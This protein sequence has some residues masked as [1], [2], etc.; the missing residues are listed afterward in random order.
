MSWLVV[1]LATMTESERKVQMS[2]ADLK[3]EYPH[4]IYEQ[5]SDST[6]YEVFV[7]AS[8]NAM[9]AAGYQIAVE[10]ESNERQG[11]ST[12]TI[13][14]KESDR[15]EQ[16]LQGTLFLGLT[17]ATKAVLLNGN[18]YDNLEVEAAGVSD[19]LLHDLVDDEEMFKAFREYYT[20]LRW[21]TD[22][23]KLVRAVFRYSTEYNEKDI[24]DNLNGGFLG[25]L[26]FD[27]G[28]D[29]KIPYEQRKNWYTADPEQI[30]ARH[31]EIDYKRLKDA[32]FAESEEGKRLKAAYARA[33]GQVTGDAY[34]RGERTITGKGEVLPRPQIPLLKVPIVEALM[35]D[36]VSLDRPKAKYNM[37]P[38]D[39]VGLLAYSS[40]E[41]AHTALVKS[42]NTRVPKDARHVFDGPSEFQHKLG[43]IWDIIRAYTEY[44]SYPD[45]RKL[46]AADLTAILDAYSNQGEIAESVRE[47]HFEYV[48]VHGQK[49]FGE[50]VH[51][52]KE[53][54]IDLL[55]VAIASSDSSLTAKAQEVM[56][57]YIGGA[58]GLVV[59]RDPLVLSRG[60]LVLIV[61]DSIKNFDPTGNPTLLKN[62]A[63]E[64]LGGK[65]KSVADLA[66]LHMTAVGLRQKPNVSLA[67]KEMRRHS[68]QIDGKSKEADVA[69]EKFN[70]LTKRS[71]NIFD[72]IRTQKNK[73]LIGL[74]D[75]LMGDGEDP[76]RLIE[77][78]INR[79]E[80]RS[81]E[82]SEL[83]S[84]YYELIRIAKLLGPGE[85]RVNVIAWHMQK[86]FEYMSK[87]SAHLLVPVVI[88]LY[89]VILGEPGNVIFPNDSTSH[90]L[91]AV[92]GLVRR[93][94]REIFKSASPEDLQVIQNYVLEIAAHA[95]RI[96]NGE[97]LPQD[98]G[99][100]VD[101]V[102]YKKWQQEKMQQIKYS[103]QQLQQ[104]GE[105]YKEFLHI[106][107][108][109]VR[110]DVY[111]PW[112]LKQLVPFYRAMQF[113]VSEGNRPN[114]A[115]RTLH[116]TLADYIKNRLVIKE[117]YPENFDVI[118]DGNLD[119][120]LYE[121][122][123]Q[124]VVPYEIK[125]NG[126]VWKEG[127][128][129][130]H[131]AISGMPESVV[132]EIEKKYPNSDFAK[133]VRKEH[134]RLQD[135]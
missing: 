90:G 1:K 46:L 70:Q 120:F 6:A 101:K 30:L 11:T 102:E 123:K 2:S 10:V 77:G 34:Y 14:T 134:D 5:V 50:G 19:K 39:V 59:D 22:Q 81:R 117:Q 84:E 87:E 100:E 28:L 9:A 95:Q 119:T 78:L 104:V 75:D 69:R 80:M 16:A 60:E 58:G 89:E 4:V 13:R 79:V 71:D 45:K 97:L 73:I 38:S 52:V 48:R 29:S 92:S 126:A 116:Q 49:Y 88:D 76:D 115:V 41:R 118:K 124:M 110:P 114:H 64:L 83:P 15:H 17:E 26:V 94:G 51:T 91:S 23:E 106:E 33:V 35:I 105:Y 44:K 82:I 62:I 107:A 74:I 67:L 108:V 53:T 68:F 21:S 57:S 37:G 99:E 113:E 122:Y 121:M 65:G 7:S 127:L 40:S 125:N 85:P 93:Q 109:K 47:G 32:T 43:N 61:L 55:Q 130:M 111:Y 132:K 66:A 129:F 72:D 42:I 98:L 20:G 133:F 31:K 135:N 18:S 27:L 112:M 131:Y 3:R 8:Y 54:V 103:L 12:Y 63:I 24:K 25:S 36:E 56:R 128:T 96:T 86:Q